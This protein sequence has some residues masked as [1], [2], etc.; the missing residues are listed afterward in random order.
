LILFSSEPALREEHGIGLMLEVSIGRRD[1]L[2]E[3]P[4]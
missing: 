2:R 3:I 1:T 4:E